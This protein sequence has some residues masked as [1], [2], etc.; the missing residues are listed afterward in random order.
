MIVRIAIGSSDRS[1]AVVEA[2]R[3]A[4]S[5][6]QVVGVRVVG[7]ES[8]LFVARL[9]TDSRVVTTVVRTVYTLVFTGTP[10]AVLTT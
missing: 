1:S 2:L 3:V 10:A 4:E 6:L 5:T 7:V 8:R 9:E